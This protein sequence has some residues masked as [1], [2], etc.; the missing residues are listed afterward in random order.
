MTHRSSV[1]LWTACFGVMLVIFGMTYLA[2]VI[3]PYLLHDIAIQPRDPGMVMPF[4]HAGYGGPLRGV[5][6]VMVAYGP[7][8]LVVLTALHGLVM[9]AST[10]VQ[11]NRY[12]RWT[13]W[14]LLGA[15]TALIVVMLS[16][17]GSPIAAWHLD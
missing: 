11:R 16:P 1:T 15:A 17:L 14:L 10:E 8:L 9:S 7:G 2:L 6:L 12:K 3:A 4:L 5:A 13:A